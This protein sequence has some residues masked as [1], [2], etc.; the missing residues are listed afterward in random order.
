MFSSTSNR[1]CHRFRRAK[2]GCLAKKPDAN[3]VPTVLCPGCKKPMLLTLLEP[4][5]GVLETA[6][7]RCDQC[8]TETKREFARGKAR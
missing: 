5:S 4:A 7:F 3:A 2:E 8:G 1:K 6:T